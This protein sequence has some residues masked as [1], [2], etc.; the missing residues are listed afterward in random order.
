MQAHESDGA[1][2]HWTHRL[3]WCIHCQYEYQQ[4]YGG[5]YSC[6]LCGQEN[7]YVLETYFY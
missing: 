1:V 7:Y 4:D 3:V 6:E 2:L 5:D